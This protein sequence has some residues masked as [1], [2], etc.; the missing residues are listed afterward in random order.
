[1]ENKERR[2]REFLGDT[3]TNSVTLM[4]IVFVIGGLA[5]AY[6]RWSLIDMAIPWGTAIL[7]AGL[8]P[9]GHAWQITYVNMRGYRTYQNAVALPQQPCPE[10]I[11]VR[12]VMTNKPVTNQPREIEPLADHEI[13]AP[14][15]KYP[16]GVRMKEIDLGWLIMQLNL[17]YTWR[18][19]SQL[20]MPSGIKLQRE[21]YYAFFDMMVALNYIVGRTRT[22]SGHLAP[23]VRVLDIR[24]AV[25][26]YR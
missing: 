15:P 17:D 24:L 13:A 16:R 3:F 12:Y 18:T 20:K 14:G 1:M 7:L 23:G 11:V 10:K 21:Q 25:L 2:Q 19:L 26:G 8:L 5:I 4:L 6:R 22:S 9:I